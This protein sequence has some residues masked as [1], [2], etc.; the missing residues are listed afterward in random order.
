MLPV[1]AYRKREE[2][3]WINAAQKRIMD[4]CKKL[5]GWYLL[6]GDTGEPGRGGSSCVCLHLLWFVRLE[7][8]TG[9]GLGPF[10]I[11]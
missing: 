11:F 10:G 4:S 9:R 3:F 8:R 2:A 6:V 1:L 5:L 7:G